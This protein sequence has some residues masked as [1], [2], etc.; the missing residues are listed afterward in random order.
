MED[1][2]H[3]KWIGEKID[4][5]MDLPFTMPYRER[6]KKFFCALLNE[7]LMRKP[8]EEQVAEDW[9]QGEPYEAPVRKPSEVEVEEKARELDKVI[10]GMFPGTERTDEKVRL[11]VYGGFI[12]ALFKEYN[13]LVGQRRRK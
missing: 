1:K 8:S 5:F 11:G 13:F 3:K 7:A 9:I 2:Q 4:E 12:S 10:M 6:L